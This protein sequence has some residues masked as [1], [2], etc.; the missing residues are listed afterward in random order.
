MTLLSKSSKGSS[1]PPTYSKLSSSGLNEFSTGV[2][3]A[4]NG[5]SVGLTEHAL[6]TNQNSSRLNNYTAH[7]TLNNTHKN[8]ISGAANNNHNKPKK[9]HLIKTNDEHHS[10]TPNIKD[11][12]TP[13]LVSEVYLTRLLATKVIFKKS[14]R[15]NYDTIEIL[16]SF[17]YMNIYSV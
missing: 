3:S 13:K 6:L 9:Y 4:M 11:D 12:K 8:S 17:D 16:T 7:Y 5:S 14:F 15:K 10:T 2:Y 1:S